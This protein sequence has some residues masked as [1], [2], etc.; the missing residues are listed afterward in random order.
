MANKRDFEGNRLHHFELSG[1]NRTVRWVLI[2]IL[3]V[4]A[5]VALTYGLMSALQ[6]PPG[7][8]TVEGNTS[9]LHC[10]EQSLHSVH[11][12]SSCREQYRYEHLVSAL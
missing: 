9:G 11:P 7:W 2:I 1:A 6:T 10:G 3:L 8:Q 12:R 4:I 5:A